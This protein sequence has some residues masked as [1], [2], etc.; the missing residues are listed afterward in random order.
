MREPWLFTER[1]LALDARRRARPIVVDEVQK[2][3]ALLDEVP[4]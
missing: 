4:A 3:P 2:V 1:V